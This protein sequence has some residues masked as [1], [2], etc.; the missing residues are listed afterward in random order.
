MIYL[1]SDHRGYEVKEK[2][3]RW[4]KEWGYDFEDLGPFDYDPQ[5]DYPE[6]VHRA[7]EKV[8]LDPEKSLGIVLGNSGQG[9]AMVANKYRHVRAVVYYGGNVPEILKLSREHNHANILSLAASFLSENET[10]EAIKIWLT[11]PYA[12]EERHIRRIKQIEQIEDSSKLG[13]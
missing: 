9:E 11:T 3:K 1:A 2:I 10:R 5:D 13:K 6:F 8:S 7:G 4:L 12:F